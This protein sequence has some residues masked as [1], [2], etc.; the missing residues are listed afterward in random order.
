MGSM[1]CTNCGRTF[2]FDLVP[3]RGAICFGCHVKTVNI[4]FTHGQETFHG[5]TLKEREREILGD[6]AKKG[7]EVEYVGNK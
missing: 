1:I 5:P 6:A 7:I 2:T 3:R 4:G